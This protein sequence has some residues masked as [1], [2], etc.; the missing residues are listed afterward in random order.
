MSHTPHELAEEFP[1]QIARVCALRISNSH[2]RKL[3]DDHHAINRAV[4]LAK[5]QI[6]PT[7]DEHEDGLRRTRLRLKDQIAAMLR[8]E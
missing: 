2:F 3:A 6:E 4:H 7:T 1:D 5:T 8:M